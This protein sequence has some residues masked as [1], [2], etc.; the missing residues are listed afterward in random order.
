M[1]WF[2]ECMKL[3]R[4]FIRALQEASRIPLVKEFWNILLTRPADICPGFTGIEQI[5]RTPTPKDVLELRISVNLANRI[6]HIFE[7]S[8]GTHRRNVAWLIERYLPPD[9]NGLFLSDIIRYIIRCIHPENEVLASPVLQRYGLIVHLLQSCLKDWAAATAKTALYYDWMFYDGP[10][11]IMDIEPGMLVMTKT[12]DGHSYFADECIEFLNLIPN[13]YY[14][15]MADEVRANIQR[16]MK[17]MVDKGVDK[18]DPLMN[19]PHVDDVTKAT[20]SHLFASSSHTRSAPVLPQSAPVAPDQMGGTEGAPNA[21]DGKASPTYSPE[22]THGLKNIVPT[23]SQLMMEEED[24][25]MREFLGATAE[26]SESDIEAEEATKGLQDAETQRRNGTKKRESPLSNPKS[27]SIDT[28]E[29]V[30]SSSSTISAPGLEVEGGE[31]PG[32]K[33]EEGVKMRESSTPPVDT[34]ALYF[35]GTKP[36]EFRDILQTAEK[37]GADPEKHA[38]SRL[39]RTMLQALACTAGTPD[40]VVETAGSSIIDD[41]VTPLGEEYGRREGG[42]G[43][44]DREESRGR[45]RQGSIGGDMGSGEGRDRKVAWY[46]PLKQGSL[47]EIL[48]EDCLADVKGRDGK[49]RQGKVRSVILSLCPR[50]TGLRSR[51]LLFLVRKALEETSVPS[52]GKPSS[53]PR[54]SELYDEWCWLLEAS[55]PGADR[56]AAFLEDIQWLETNQ[57]EAL[58]AL[59]PTL[60]LLVPGSV[61]AQVEVFNVVIEMMEPRQVLRLSQSLMCRESVVFGDAASSILLA[62]LDL[63][64]FQQHY[65]WSLAAAEFGGSYLKLSGWMRDLWSQLTG[66]HDDATLGLL[67]ILRG[68][69][70]YKPLIRDLFSLPLPSSD[71]AGLGTFR[72]SVLRMCLIQWYRSWP[73]TLG[74]HLAQVLWIASGMIGQRSR[75]KGEEDADGEEDEGIVGEDGG[76]ARRLLSVLVTLG[77]DILMPL[78]RV[79]ELRKVIK[80]LENDSRIWD[81]SYHASLD[82][83]LAQELLSEEEDEG[84]EDEGVKEDKRRPSRKKATPLKKA[85]PPRKTSVSSGSKAMGESVRSRKSSKVLSDTESNEEEE[86]EEENAESEE[87][88]NSRASRSKPKPSGK[89]SDRASKDRS[90]SGGKRKASVTSSSSGSGESDTGDAGPKAKTKAKAREEETKIRT[91]L[92]KRLP[93]RKGKK[94]RVD[95]D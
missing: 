29:P 50:N 75:E 61:T 6:K 85:G 86:D 14:P 52:P 33:G 80:E 67:S 59:L 66:K 55:S 15:P 57:Y 5:L 68:N 64:S 45:P 17:L 1:L 30:S 39:L 58:Q 31:Q 44:G 37:T 84:E 2:P 27:A 40:V 35:F 32:P 20:V 21:K 19:D 3:G 53:S 88:G 71:L 70:P 24:D 91:T 12:L 83:A 90:T 28:N 13:A 69:P 42:E 47:T 26:D 46:D 92:S 78:L 25:A 73:K 11:A 76:L 62:S 22:T 43:N 18:L 48:F 63:G 49:E 56:K 9:D 7:I 77:K 79:R 16:A 4:D 74:I 10:S 82:C 87:E 94:Q 41:L 93:P 23:P 81:S 8:F 54:I 38:L 34:R 72:R 36:Q 89:A 51:W 60:Y 95:S 65:T